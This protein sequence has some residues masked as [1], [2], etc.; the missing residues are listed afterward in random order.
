MNVIRFQV[1]S[2]KQ[3]ENIDLMV[4]LDGNLRDR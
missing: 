1:F 3:I 2:H 4:A